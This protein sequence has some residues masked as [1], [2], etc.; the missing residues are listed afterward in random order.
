[1]SIVSSVISGIRNVTSRII[2]IIKRFVENIRNRT[3]YPP[4]VIEQRAHQY[5]TQPEVPANTEKALE[6]ND[7]VVELMNDVFHGKHP[8][9]YLNAIEDFEQR[10]KV[11]REFATRLLELY[12]LTD[13][14]V[15]FEHLDKSY[16]GCYSFDRKT[17]SVNVS[18]LTLNNP[19]LLLD[20]VDTVLHESR[21]ALQH[22]AM[23]GHNPLGFDEE[24]IKSWI[25]NMKNYIRLENDPKGYR[26]QPVE[27]DAFD[28]SVYT[29]HC[30]LHENK[31]EE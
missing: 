13:V 30:Y 4:A 19:V 8:G 1:M 26:E 11:F 17:L 22:A 12:G 7:R 18:Y 29:I 23:Y 15:A 3:E 14:K 21:H 27:K 5:D 16:A 31:A 24:T 28:S 2:D 25:K 6:V 9:E 20:A 10:E